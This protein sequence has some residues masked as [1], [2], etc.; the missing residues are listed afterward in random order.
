MNIVI[1]MAG[2]GNRFKLAGYKDPKPLIKIKDNYMIQLVVKNLNFD[3]RF[4]FI[5]QKEHEAQFGIISKLKELTPNCEF[6][7]LNKITNGAACTVLLA[8]EYIDNNE[9]LIIANS[10]QYID[11]DFRDFVNVNRNLISGNILTYESDDPNCSFVK[12]EESGTV[13]EV[14]EKKVISNIATVGVYYWSKGS[15]F[16]KYAKQ[17][18]YKNIKTN[19]EFYVAPVYNEAIADGKKITIYNT[20]NIY[21]IG[22]PELL[23]HF[24][25]MDI[26]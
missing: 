8:K 3:G 9:P 20:K 10:D 1:P 17:M 18:I 7:L 22:T 15:D 13:I 26:I 4:I 21:N 23:E 14:A 19:N 11:T 16:V 25:K 12:T 2:A 6:I 24:I 5:I